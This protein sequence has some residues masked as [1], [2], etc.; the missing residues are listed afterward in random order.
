MWWC[1]A[2]LT[3]GSATGHRAR[4]GDAMTSPLLEFGDS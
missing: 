4:W 3:T 1:P 2:R